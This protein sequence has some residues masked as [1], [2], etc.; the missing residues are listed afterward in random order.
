MAL[1]VKNVLKSLSTL[2]IVLISHNKFIIYKPN[3]SFYILLPNS[4]NIKEL[5]ST[6]IILKVENF[7]RQ[8]IVKWDKWGYNTNQMNQEI[9]LPF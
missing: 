5:I 3:V 2:L 8:F 6:N 4:E 9:R 1:S 7:K